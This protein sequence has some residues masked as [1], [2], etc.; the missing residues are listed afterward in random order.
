MSNQKDYTAQIA[1]LKT[2]TQG[3]DPTQMTHSELG[4]SQQYSRK[5]Y[6]SPAA[7][8]KFHDSQFGD[9]KTI[10]TEEG[11]LHRSQKA[12][13]AKYKSKASYREAQADHIDAAKNVHSRVVKDPIKRALLS[14][15]DVKNVINRDD[16]FQEKSRHENASKGA[17]S[18]FQRGVEQH[19]AKRALKG[20]EK[21][22][23]TD[24]QLTVKATENAGKIMLENAKD[25]VNVGTQTALVAL[26]VSGLNNLVNI[27]SGEKDV[28]TALKD[29]ATDVSSSFISSAG[30]RMTQDVV[31]STANLFGAQKVAE[32]A[33]QQV[34]VAEIA[35][36]AMT[37]N[38]VKK[39]LDGNIS[40]ED[41]VVQIIQNGTGAIAC[42]LGAAIGGPAGAVVASIVMT[43]ITTAVEEYRQEK[44]LTKKRD[45]E[46]QNLLTEAQTELQ[47]QQRSLR[48]YTEQEL[49]RWDTAIDSG[50]Q[51]IMDATMANDADG[52]AA[53]LD[54][55]M[56]LFGT[57]VK[58]KSL[59]EFEKDFFSD[60][61]TVL[62][63]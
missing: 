33:A 16:N 57:Q 58:Y 53:G 21:Q 2:T 24:I 56:N 18:E 31:V 23:E 3:I 37:I 62:T 7:R 48:E 22:V 19:D 38:S 49:G 54:T 45:A 25:A 6:D 59:S 44:K 60:T 10:Q 8:R 43:Q 26:T 9:K 39:Y 27:A 32:I 29:I 12:A 28:E 63:L 61:S 51:T 11:V 50:F 42:Q 34:P 5:L 55:I 35:M 4:V 47:R 17:Q 40:A 14:D 36:A 46:I 20:I 13:R 15:E 52:I 41:C 30:L 1:A